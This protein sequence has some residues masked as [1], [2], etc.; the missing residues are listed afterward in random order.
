MISNHQNRQAGQQIDQ[1]LDSPRLDQKSEPLGLRSFDYLE[2]TDC[3]EFIDLHAKSV[4]VSD[5]KFSLMGLIPGLLKC[6]KGVCPRCQEM[7][8]TFKGLLESLGEK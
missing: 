7:R 1:F 3:H 5:W 6:A 8:K 4:D 2:C